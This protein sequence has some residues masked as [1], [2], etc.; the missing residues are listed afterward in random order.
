MPKTAAINVEFKC[1]AEVKDADVACNLIR[2]IV[3]LAGTNHGFICITN[4]LSDTGKRAN[5]VLQPF[6]EM[7]Y[8][9]LVRESLEILERQELELPNEID[10]LAIEK[11]V[12]NEAILEQITSFRKTLDGGHG[13]KDDKEKIRKGFYELDGSVYV[14]NVRIAKYHVTDEQDKHNATLDQQKVK[15]TP[16]SAK[17]KAKNWLRNNT[18]ASNFRGQFRLNADKFDRIAFSRSV[19][20]FAKFGELFTP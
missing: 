8:P 2:N 18:P 15:H 9:R 3:E 7:A 6:G 16:K 4:Y 5:Y 13:R 10:G 19:I 20:E 17:A 1:P 12:W 14:A 11:L